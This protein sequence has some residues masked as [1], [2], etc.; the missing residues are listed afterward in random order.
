MGHNNDGVHVESVNI[1]SYCRFRTG[2]AESRS[3][4]FEHP[5]PAATAACSQPLL[6]HSAKLFSS[7]TPFSQID[8]PHVTLG[9]PGLNVRYIC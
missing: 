2:F 8:L 1:C 4:Q 5:C 3:N 9:S 7:F 6:P